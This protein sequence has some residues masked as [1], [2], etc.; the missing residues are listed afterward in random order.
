MCAQRVAEQMRSPGAL[1]WGS[2]GGSGSW[3]IS[4]WTMQMP[5]FLVHVAFTAKG[6]AAF[7]CLKYHVKLNSHM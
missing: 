1:P 4:F 3:A 6:R 2:A 7:F 5:C